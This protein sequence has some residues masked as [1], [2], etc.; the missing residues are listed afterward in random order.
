MSFVCH[1]DSPPTLC[2]KEAFVPTN[3]SRSPVYLSQDAEDAAL[4]TRCLQGDAQAFEVIVGRYQRTLFS[5]AVRMLGD[6]EDA[7]DATQ[8]AFVRAY[9]KLGTFKTGHRFFSWLYR[10]LVNECLNAIRSR[11]STTDESEAEAIATGGPLEAL[12]SSERRRLVQRALLALP[13]DLRMVVVLRHY[14]ELSYEEIG[15]AIGGL[16]VKT[17][18]SRLYTARQRL[19]VLLLGWGSER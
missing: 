19:G 9:E 11:R 12:E 17:V 6:R 5:V 4:V 3:F 1:P 13:P 14:G 16:P 15:E 10:I 8:N 18:K 7:F 2:Y